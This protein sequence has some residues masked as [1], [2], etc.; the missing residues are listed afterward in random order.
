MKNEQPDFTPE[1]SSERFVPP[2]LHLPQLLLLPETPI[3]TQATRQFQRITK[4]TPLVSH[5]RVL[6]HTEPLKNAISIPTTE[7]HSLPKPQLPFPIHHRAIA[8]S[9]RAGVTY[10]PASM[11]RRSEPNMIDALIACA[12]LLLLVICVMLL[13]YYFSV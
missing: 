10:I 4:N 12:T 7:D 2:M 8:S 9:L 3:R 1:T 13:F 6:P 11:Q 5:P